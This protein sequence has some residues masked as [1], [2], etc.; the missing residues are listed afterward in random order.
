MHGQRF[1]NHSITQSLRPQN[2]EPYGCNYRS[3][4]KCPL[5]NKCLTPKVIYQANVTNNSNN[6]EKFYRVLAETPF[7]DRFRNHTKEF[8]HKKYYKNTE[9]SQYIWQL[10][11][12]DIS[13]DISWEI[14]AQVYSNTRINFCVLCLTEKLKIIDVLMTLDY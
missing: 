2:S 8:K 12:S 6:D 5:P 10:K 3:Q 14:I 11:V 1:I 4:P 13:P 7:K 9:F